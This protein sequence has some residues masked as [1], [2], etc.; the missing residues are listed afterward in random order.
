MCLLALLQWLQV[1]ATQIST[2][3]PESLLLL[4]TPAPAGPARPADDDS[5]PPGALF[6]H[7]GLANGV[8]LRSEVLDE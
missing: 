2:S 8:L 3:P 4:D 7:A 1:K 6:L 5:A